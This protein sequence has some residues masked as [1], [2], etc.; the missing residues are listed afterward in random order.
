[1]SAFFRRLF[2]VNRMIPESKR[3]GAVPTTRA[4]YK[5]VLTIALPSVAEMVLVSLVGS[6]DTM[7]IGPLG[8]AAIA[9]VGLT[10]QPR[11]ILLSL[12]FAL[13]IGVTAVVARRKGEGQQG[14]AN[15]A[16]RTAIMLII[17]LALVIMAIVY[18]F[19]RQ[20]MWLA[21][22]Q[23]DTVDMAYDYFTIVNCVLPLNA[24]TMCINAAQRGI[25]NTRVALYVNILSNV[26]NIILDL[27]LIPIL[28][29][30]G[31]AIASAVGFVA[32]FVLSLYS[33]ISKRSLGRF[34][35]LSIRDKWRPSKEAMTSIAKVGGNSVVEQLALR[36]GFFIYARF[37]ADL[38]TLAFA[39]HQVC[40]QFL[41]LSFSYGDGVG[42]AGTSLVGQMLGKKRPDLAMMYGKVSQR[43]ALVGAL[44]IMTIIVIFRYPLV[45]IFSRD[46]GVVALAGS[47]M[48]MVAAFQPMQTSAVVISGALRGAGDTKFVAG[49]ML[50]CVALLRPLLAFVGI[51]HLGLDLFGAWAA[52]L[53][54][55]AIRLTLV[56]T[57]FNS[58]KWFAIK[59]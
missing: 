18:P 53:I 59:V 44:F 14:K 54:D 19:S 10:N 38:G 21:G 42:V 17:P 49:T 1:M 57:R 50:L 3:L 28:G 4:A 45:M 26:V 7:L 39:S 36:V 32:G 35:H 16:L 46:P 29:V 11:M 8:P 47:V 15:E 2:S 5:D 41:S 31:D 56:Y 13:N 12:F 43:I 9:A 52:S 25:G 37:V 6:V 24:L 27:M 20:L 58:G 40:M 34:L 23:E 33:V 30:K 51:Y 48:L 22:A 55:M